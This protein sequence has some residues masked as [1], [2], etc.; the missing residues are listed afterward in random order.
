MEELLLKHIQ[1]LEFLH[2]KGIMTRVL[3]SETFAEDQLK[4]MQ[5]QKEYLRR[6]WFKNTAIF[7]CRM[8][9]R[10]NPYI[11]PI[12]KQKEPVEY[13]RQVAREPI[14]SAESQARQ[15]MIR[16]LEQVLAAPVDLTHSGSGIA[17]FAISLAAG[18]A[19]FTAIIFAGV[20]GIMG[21]GMVERESPIVVI[22]GIVMVLGGLGYIVGLALGIVGAAERHRKKTFA[23]VGI[24]LNAI[25][26]VILGGLIALGAIL[27]P[28]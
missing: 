22:V 21:G 3:T 10:M 26:L 18:L 1:G 24:I 9:S 19:E 12:E 11:G 16:H 28:R 25:G 7:V 20:M 2:S 6:K 15:N 27:G 14:I 5:K 23:V 4:G 13:I 17:S 8:G